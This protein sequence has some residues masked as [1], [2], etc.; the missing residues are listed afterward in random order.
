MRCSKPTNNSPAALPPRTCMP[1]STRPPLWVPRDDELES[2]P[3]NEPAACAKMPKRVT[4]NRLVVD[5]AVDP[6]KDVVDDVDLAAKMRVPGKP[7]I[8]DL[9]RL[10]RNVELPAREELGRGR[11]RRWRRQRPLSVSVNDRKKT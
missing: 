8:V 10:R 6:A 7:R 3:T 2:I 9:K 11:C 5:D 4:D 1:A